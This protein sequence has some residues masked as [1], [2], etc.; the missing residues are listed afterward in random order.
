MNPLAVGIL[1]QAGNQLGSFLP[2]LGGALV[3]LILGL[4]IARLVGRLLA[5]ALHGAGLDGFADRVG[6]G[7][8]LAR[9]GL[10]P[11]LSRVVAVA[12]RIAISIVVV[13]AALSLLGLQFLSQSLNQGVLVLPKLLIGAALLLVG[14]V[15]GG[16]VR[17]RVE[18]LTYQMDFPV[19]DRAGDRRRRIRDHRRGTDRDLHD[20]PADPDRR[21]PRRG[22]RDVRARLRAGWT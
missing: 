16:F 21:D 12:I 20:R 9:A 13:F 14:V 11:S 18:R 15:L 5:K 6:A 17:E 2:R 19:R 8:V 4:L 10:G 22:C 1:D 7:E 3:L